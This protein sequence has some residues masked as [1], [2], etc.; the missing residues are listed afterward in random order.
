MRDIV[1]SSTSIRMYK[2]CNWSYFL[3]YVM[4]WRP[5]ED[6]GYFR[7]GSHWAKLQEIMS[8][9]PHDLCPECAAVDRSVD[10]DCY[11]CEGGGTVPDDL[12]TAGA[13]YLEYAYSDMPENFDAHR[14]ETEKLTILYAFTGYR[15]LYPENEYEVI[16]GEIPFSLPII[17]PVTNRKLPR[18]RLDGM[19][20]QLWRHKASGRIVIGE[21]KSTGSN[22]GDG[23]FWDKLKMSG[24]VQTYSYA[25]WLLWTGGALKQ[26]G[27]N[28]SD[29]QIVTPVYDVWMKPSIKPK[30]LSQ[31]DSKKL[32]ETGEYCGKKFMVT[33]S[34]LD[35]ENKVC[36]V[37]Y[38]YASVEP[39]AK[40]GQY[41]IHETPEMYAE[42]LLVD[43][44]ER[45]DFYFARKE[46][47]VD[48]N[49]LAEF[50]VDC[51]KLVQTIRYIEKENLWIRNGKS[52]KNP[53]KC[54]FYKACH[55]N[56]RFALSTEEAPE[57]YRT[58]LDTAS[59][60]KKQLEE[61]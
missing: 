57:G 34:D 12:A 17:D 53:G 21:Q 42:R 4:G 41:A 6:K 22:L 24:Q 20:D 45:P 7:I 8:Y 16:A 33:P 47:P 39:G 51:S 31:S 29:A 50:A 5:E 37:N 44:T 52:C 25:M 9:K 30:K 18:C 49:D 43:I 23:G 55:E 36:T 14:W 27:L 56:R 60:E 28:P 19:I 38:A 15:W 2:D 58:T 32:V 40:E 48:E 59:L 61:M 26:Y 35:I 1:L 46:I 54:D 13:R 11:L 3:K 10:P